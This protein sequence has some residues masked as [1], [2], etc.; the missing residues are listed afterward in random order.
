MSKL[1]W[2]IG[3]VALAAMGCDNAAPPVGTV[4]PS[5]DIDV[6]PTV[7]GGSSIAQQA[8]IPGEVVR[9]DRALRPV[10]GGTLLVLRD[11]KTAIV[12]D[13]DRDQ[14]FVVDL[15][16]ASVTR[17]I[18]LEAGAEPGRAVEDDLGVVHV[19]LR[20]SGK[21]LTFDPIRGE[22]LG[23]RSVCAYPRGVAA[24]GAAVYVACAD[25]KLVTLSTNAAE[26][27]PLRTLTLDRDLRDVVVASDGLWVSR[28]RSAEVL[29]LD[30]TGKVLR[31]TRLPSLLGGQGESIS[32]VAW[33]MVPSANGGVVVV[34]QR[35]FAGEVVLTP[36][37]YGST[38]VTGG[39]VSTAVTTV[40]ENGEVLGTSVALAAPL[41]V[42]I[43]QSAVSGRFLLASAAI[44]HPEQPSRFG[45]TLLVR[46]GDLGLSDVPFEA[47][48]VPPP[49]SIGAESNIPS[50]QLV[51]V[52]FA[53]DTP[54]LQYRD[55]S[56]LVVGSRGI[57]LPGESVEDTGNLLFHLETSSGLACASCHPEGQ[58]DGQTWHFAGFG[59]RRTQSLRGGLLGTEPFHWDGMEADFA[60][61]TG[62]VM[63][64]RMGG[65]A[66]TPEQN[67]ALAGY[68]DVLPAMPAPRADIT[69]SVARGQ[70]LFN[71]QQ[72]GCAT[73]HGGSRFSN[74][75]T[76]DV[77]SAD[78]MLQVPGLVGLWARAPYLHDG[79]A[80]TLMD[81][82]TTCDT[83]QHG[84]VAQLKS[85]DL[86]ALTDY[87]ETL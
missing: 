60:F 74:D 48:S 24:A 40:T 5:P 64:G 50:G 36:G 34:H 78:G 39:M 56:S 46:P 44:E 14:L 72:V 4:A 58:E 41:P 31:R 85:D 49:L 75:Q 57:T 66:L 47:G 16:Q 17:T 37:G 33:R 11:E 76:V 7:G 51:A 26:T 22:Q 67:T 43:A 18:T 6:G 23:T 54:V 3:A 28:F 65:P 8:S 81:R 53:G 62:D 61:L 86:R 21:L 27:A 77:G 9:A 55:P 59:P 10:S 83:G 63:Q 38:G 79:C 73:C 1:V 20:G 71:D 52:A 35:A 68:L 87:L 70:Q 80:K 32:S 45:R 19:A 13:P 42:D 15:E 84:Q 12:A 82:F 2:G 25:G 69:A 30:A 29:R